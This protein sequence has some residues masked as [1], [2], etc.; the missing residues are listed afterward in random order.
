MNAF[1]SYDYTCYYVAGPSNIIETALDILSDVVFHPY[2]DPEELKKE[3]EVVIEEMKMRLDNP[4]TVLFENVMKASYRNFPY[5]RPI[6]G[7]PETVRS[8]TRKNLLDYVNEFYTPENMVLVIVGN[9]TENKL[10]PLVEKYFSNLPKRKLKKIEFPEEPYTEKPEL[11]WIERPVKEGYFVFTLPGPSI[12]SNDAPILDLIA[13][14]LGGGKSSR[15]Y[16]KLKREL[17]LVKSISASSFTPTGPGLFEIYG[18]ADPEN[19]LKIIKETLKELEK[20]KENGVEDEELEKAK[21]Q[22]GQKSSPKV[23]WL[24]FYIPLRELWHHKPAPEPLPLKLQDLLNAD[25][26]ENPK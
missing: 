17:G 18:T 23:F 20:L 3:K 12:K 4:M 13:E 19:F 15:L 14:I 21:I 11:I 9:I 16:V 1:T 22:I 6:I 25:S 5:Y 2:F 24:Q 7:F 26:K 8:F 10:F